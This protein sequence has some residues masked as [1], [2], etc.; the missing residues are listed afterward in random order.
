MTNK[1]VDYKWYVSEK[2]SGEYSSF[3]KRAFPRAIYAK[4]TGNETTIFTI[5]VDGKSFRTIKE[6]DGL[7][8]ELRYPRKTENGKSF[9]WRVFTK[10]FTSYEELKAFAEKFYLENQDIIYKRG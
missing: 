6:M 8:M 5:S 4:D 10:K 2:P 3:E 1:K 7:E 9:T